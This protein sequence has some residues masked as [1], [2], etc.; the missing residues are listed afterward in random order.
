MF[1]IFFA[2][3]RFQVCCFFMLAVLSNMLWLLLKSVNYKPM[4][5]TGKV[6]EGK[7][8]VDRIDP[9]IKDNLVTVLLPA[10]INRM[11]ALKEQQKMQLSQQNKAN[12]NQP[13]PNRI[14]SS[15]TASYQ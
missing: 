3:S 5:L 7:Y 9:V 2:E 11:D 15:T 1:S 13:P 4:A 6:M 14:P 10:D 8:I 12:M